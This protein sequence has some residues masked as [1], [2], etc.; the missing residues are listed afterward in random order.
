MDEVEKVEQPEPKRRSP[1]E[2]FDELKAAVNRSAAEIAD[3][4]EFSRKVKDKLFKAA[5]LH[6]MDGMLP[7]LDSM[8][9]IHQI[10][11]ARVTSMRGNGKKVK[12]DAETFIV[13]LLET[14]EEELARH[15]IDT[16][17]PPRGAA[18]DVHTMECTRT[19]RRSKKDEGNTVAAVNRCGFLYKPSSEGAPR[20][21]AKAQVEVFEK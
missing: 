4:W 15:G 14:L 7:L 8:L 13:T 1:A 16:V 3:L 20:V 6:R 19:V 9:Q 21:L 2:A 11:F 5:E 10:L 17:E 18:F 12:G